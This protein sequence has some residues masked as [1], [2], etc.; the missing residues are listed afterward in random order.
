MGVC[1]ER[2]DREGW[3]D[4]QLGCGPR[5]DL[6]GAR[7]YE[8]SVDLHDSARDREAGSSG[9]CTDVWDEAACRRKGAG[10]AGRNSVSAAEWFRLGLSA[11]AQQFGQRVFPESSASEIRC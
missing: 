1:V 4:G 3:G 8:L 2:V 6:Y 7:I 10:C 11:R 5:R 9:L